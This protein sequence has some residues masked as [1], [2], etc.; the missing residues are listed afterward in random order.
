MNLD[1]ENRQGSPSVRS[2][3]IEPVITGGYGVGNREHTFSSMETA[4]EGR[5]TASR[6]CIA[7]RPGSGSGS[8]AVEANNLLRVFI[9]IYMVD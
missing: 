9:F 3:S 7:S 4:K 2:G 6:L 1:G 8:M 5:E